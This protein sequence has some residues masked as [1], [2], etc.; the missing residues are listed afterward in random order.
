MRIGITKKSFLRWMKQIVIALAAF[1]ACLPAISQPIS[2]FENAA[3]LTNG[4]GSYMISGNLANTRKYTRLAEGTPFYSDEYLPA[5]VYM[6]SGTYITN[7]PVKINLDDMEVYYRDKAGNEMVITQPLTKLVL[8]PAAQDSILFR[9]FPKERAA[10]NEQPTGWLLQLYGTRG[11]E[12]Y[13]HFDKRAEETTVYGQATKELRVLTYYQYWAWYGKA[14]TKM[15]KLEE[16]ADL[17]PVKKDA[18]AKDFKSKKLSTRQ[19][20]DWVEACRVLES[21]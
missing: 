8:Y 6:P 18:I 20:A 11:M 16:M 15:K 21:L 10:V 7:L 13:K 1:L 17:K 19:D 9:W 2:T 4:S 3:V 5:T 12:L 14:W